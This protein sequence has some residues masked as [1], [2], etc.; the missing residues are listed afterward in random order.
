MAVLNQ[1][2]A[3]GFLQPRKEQQL[4]AEAIQSLGIRAFSIDQIVGKLSGGN[5]QK[6]VIAKWLASRPRLS[7]WMNPRAD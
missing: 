2:S 3:L 7:S 6:V 1:V 4:A 5:Q